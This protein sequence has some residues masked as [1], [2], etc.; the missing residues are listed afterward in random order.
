MN[1]V[2]LVEIIRGNDI[3]SIHFGSVAVVN[4]RGD[5]LY[6][7]GNPDF[8]T[9]TRSTIKPFQAEPFLRAGGPARFG[10]TTREVALLCASHSG[11]PMHT[12]AV[13]SMLR[14]AGCSEHHLRCGCHE[15]TVYAATDT[16]AP[17]GETWSQLHYN[18]N[19]KHA[20]F[21]ASGLQH[22]YPLLHLQRL[23]YWKNGAGRK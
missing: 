14:K 16:P 1:H 23:R 22:G 2:P 17:I 4:T 8:L 10:F 15:P 13:Q 20:V 3:E 9:F 6:Q 12:E 21:L 5:L 7:A 19:G 18:C 11:E